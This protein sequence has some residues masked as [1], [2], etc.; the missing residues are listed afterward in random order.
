MLKDEAV[1]G[2]SPGKLRVVTAGLLLKMNPRPTWRSDCRPL[3]SVSW[4]VFGDHELTSHHLQPSQAVEIGQ[5]SAHHG[6]EATDA[7]V[8]RELSHIQGVLHQRVSIQHRRG[9]VAGTGDHHGHRTAVSKSAVTRPAVTRP[10]ICRYGSVIGATVRRGS[11]VQPC[12][13]GHAMILE[14]TPIQGA[15]RIRLPASS[16]Q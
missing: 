9:G 11:P 6:E 10:C 1:T 7:R 12:A 5:A 13:A 4:W 16:I 3:T 14:T 15:T 2:S 8:W